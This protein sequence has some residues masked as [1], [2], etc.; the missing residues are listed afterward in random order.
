MKRKKYDD[1]LRDN[2]LVSGPFADK[3]AAIFSS[4]NKGKLPIIVGYQ[5][6]GTPI[7][8]PAGGPSN[9]IGYTAEGKPIYAPGT[10]GP[11]EQGGI[12]GYAPDGTP[13]YALPNTNPR[14]ATVVLGTYVKDGSPIIGKKTITVL[15]FVRIFKF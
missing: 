2:P 7:Y 11:N 13:I 9:I 8:G 5:K 15:G 12:M 14:E 10:G 4:E 3:L 1:H 6:D